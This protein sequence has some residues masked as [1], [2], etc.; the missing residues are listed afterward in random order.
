MTIPNF[1]DF[2]PEGDLSLEDAISLVMSSVAM[3]EI[4]LSKLIDAETNKLLHIVNKEDSCLK[5]IVLLNNSID[6]T[7]KDITKLEILLQHKLESISAMLPQKDCG[8]DG[9]TKRPKIPGGINAACCCT[10]GSLNCQIKVKGSG[11]ITS[12]YGE[13]FGKEAKIDVCAH[14]LVLPDSYVRYFINNTGNLYIMEGI[15]SEIIIEG[16]LVTLKGEGIGAGKDTGKKSGFINFILKI[17]V[18][19]EKESGFEITVTSK[20]PAL[21]HKSGFVKFVCKD[22][23]INIECR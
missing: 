8:T 7:V 13:F 16:N 12:R 20:N 2:K 5:D 1:Q 9:C 15:I 11:C 17:K 21:Q 4:S 14:T 19:G 10:D 18:C 3:E 23:E 22:S 6:R